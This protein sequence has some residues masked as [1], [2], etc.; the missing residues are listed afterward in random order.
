MPSGCLYLS[1]NVSNWISHFPSSCFSET[2]LKESWCLGSHGQLIR[3][4]YGRLN[5]QPVMPTAESLKLCF[6]GCC[7]PCATLFQPSVLL[8]FYEL[9]CHYS[10]TRFNRERWRGKD[11]SI[12]QVF[13]NSSRSESVFG[14]IALLLFPQTITLQNHLNVLSSIVFSLV[15]S[16]S[17]LRAAA[18]DASWSED[19][20]N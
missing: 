12:I 20:G 6:S 7:K 18:E 8:T 9:L 15:S 4:N 1:K 13:Y 14:T 3:S 11:W 5:F 2:F 16:F 10:H 17:F 19:G